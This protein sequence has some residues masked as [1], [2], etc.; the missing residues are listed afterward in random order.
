MSSL[1]LQTICTSRNSLSQFLPKNLMMIIKTYSNMLNRYQKWNVKLN[2]D[3]SKNNK[4]IL[5]RV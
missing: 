2:F 1:I 5:V 3:Q 4:I